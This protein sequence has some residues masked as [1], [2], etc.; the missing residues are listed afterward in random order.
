MR[1][2]VT[3]IN[4]TSAITFLFSAVTFRLFTVLCNHSDFFFTSPSDPFLSF[5]FFFFFFS[6][7]SFLGVLGVSRDIL[8][9]HEFVYFY[10][11]EIRAISLYCIKQEPHLGH[12]EYGVLT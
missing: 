10:K 3:R 12:M 8:R 7:N 1:Y 11:R 2:G 6:Y 5:F 9:G 4:L